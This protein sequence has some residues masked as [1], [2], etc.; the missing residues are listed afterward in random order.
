MQISIFDTPVQLI[1]ATSSV[2]GKKAAAAIDWK[3]RIWSELFR[4]D[5]LNGMVEFDSNVLNELMRAAKAKQSPYASGILG[6]T[7]KLISIV[8]SFKKLLTG[9]SNTMDHR[10]MG[11]GNLF[12]QIF[13][14]VLVFVMTAIIVV[15]LGVVA[16]ILRSK[17]D[18]EIQMETQ[19]VVDQVGQFFAVLSE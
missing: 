2:P 10:P 18:T 8:R 12:A 9:S 6:A 4:Q 17:I 5:P 11:V 14:Y 15:P 13:L 7:D 16:W 3:K 19:R 1:Q